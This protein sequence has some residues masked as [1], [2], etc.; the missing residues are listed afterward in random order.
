MIIGLLGFIGSGKGTAGDILVNQG[1]IKESFAGSLKDVTAVM[2]DWPRHLLEGDTETSRKFRET[3]DRFWSQ[4]FGRDFTPREALQKMGTESV[5]EVF[6]ENF[7]VTALEKKMRPDENYVIS[8]VR[9]KNE[10]DWIKSQ[11]GKLIEVQRGFKPH[12]YDIAA[13]CYRGDTKAE[14]FMLEESG[15]HQSEWRWVGCNPDAV[16]DNVGTIEQLETSLIKCLTKFYWQDTMKV[17]N[18]MNYDGVN[19]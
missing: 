10:I 14:R 12:W 17:V 4:K 15:V 3:P 7:W 5:R 19:K 2:F 8:D 13:K 18:D 9:F 11:G 1:L 6:H 16:I